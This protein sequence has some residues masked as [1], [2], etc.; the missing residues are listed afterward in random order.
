[1]T[2]SSHPP[3]LTRSGSF[4]ESD[5]ED[6]EDEDV[7][8]KEQQVR[9]DKQLKRVRQLDDDDS[10][11]GEQEGGGGAVGQVSPNDHHQEEKYKRQNGTLLTRQPAPKKMRKWVDSDSEVDSDNEGDS[12]SGVESSPAAA[13][14]GEGKRDDV[15]LAEEKSE[16]AATG[17]RGGGGEESDSEGEGRLEIDVDHQPSQRS[18]HEVDDIESPVQDTMALMGDGSCRGCGQTDTQT[19]EAGE[20]DL[21]SLTKLEMTEHET[22]YDFSE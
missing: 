18:S 11:D 2:V 6:M 15:E 9:V 20:D 14:S 21:G 1:M 4:F 8:E 7:S 17:Q 13:A 19:A 16:L 5:A 10:T 22:A 3:R 12:S